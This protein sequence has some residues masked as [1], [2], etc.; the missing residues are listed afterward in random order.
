MTPNVLEILPMKRSLSISF[1]AAVASGILLAA[2]S[3]TPAP[4]SLATAPTHIGIGPGGGGPPLSNDPVVGNVKVCNNGDQA[5]VV[6]V[7]VSP[8]NGGNPTTVA[9]SVSLNPAEC[10]LVATDFDNQGPTVGANVTLTETSPG[11]HLVSKDSVDNSGVETDDLPFSNGGTVFVNGNVGFTV[12]FHNVLPKA[13]FVIGD[14]EAHG[15]GATVNF[16]GSQWWKNNIM[17]QGSSSGTASFKG[18]ASTSGDVCG[19]TWTSRPGNSSNPPSSLDQDIAVM[20]TDKVTKNGSVIS[21]TVKA[22]VLVHQDGGYGPNPGHDGN[23]V[24]T[25]VVCGQ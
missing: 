6:D 4:T 14:G 17:T 3:D 10:K 12:N 21:G 11:L 13:L 16:W 5:S 18:Y 15:V 7:V 24:V 1:V 23:G 20:V 22:I 19:T 9:S 2:C 8:A 25:R